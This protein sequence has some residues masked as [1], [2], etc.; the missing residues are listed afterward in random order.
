MILLIFMLKPLIV[1]TS[2]NRFA[3]AVITSTNN[4]CFRA[5]LRKIGIP[6]FDYIKVGF[7]VETETQSFTSGKHFREMFS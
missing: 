7:N 2:Y 1:G 5:K 3:E 6:Q 4:L